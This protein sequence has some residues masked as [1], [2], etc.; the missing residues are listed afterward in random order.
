MLKNV[1]S[2]NVCQKKTRH[3][4]KKIIL[5]YMY[6]LTEK[7][8]GPKKSLKKEVHSISNCAH[9]IY[10]ARFEFS[11]HTSNFLSNAFIEKSENIFPNGKS[12]KLIL[13]L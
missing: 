13:S 12:I 1:K 11:L 10:C 5:F 6:F 2:W 7:K 9:L 8:I 4:R 3:A